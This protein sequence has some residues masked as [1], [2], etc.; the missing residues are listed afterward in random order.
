MKNLKVKNFEEYEFKPQETV[1]NICHIYLNLIEDERFCLAVS[2]DGRSYSPALF[3][4]AQKVLQKIRKPHDMIVKFVEF[5]GT[6]KV[7]ILFSIIF[8]LD[9]F[10]R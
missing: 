2:Q 4:Q 10:L 7:I 9:P 8:Y 5:A 6:V 1:S 3:E